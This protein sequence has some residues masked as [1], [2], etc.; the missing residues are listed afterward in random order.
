[1]EITKWRLFIWIKSDSSKT[2][3]NCLER[4]GASSAETRNEMV[5]P[6]LPKTALRT[7][8][9]IWEIY[10]LATVR[11]RPYLRAS[12][13]ITAKESVAKFWNSST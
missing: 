3:A 1:M 13:R 10:W 9:V 8:S 5:V 7:F 11:L 2:G 6:T 12:E 4:I